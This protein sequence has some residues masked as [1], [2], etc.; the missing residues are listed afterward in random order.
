MVDMT[1]GKVSISVA[2]PHSWART[3]ELVHEH[4]AEVQMGVV[5]EIPVSQLVF[6][7]IGKPLPPYTIVGICAPPLAF[8]ALS[9]EPEIGA[10]LPCNVCV[11][12]DA[13]GGVHVTAMD[14]QSVLPLVDHPDVEPLAN[15]VRERLSRLL[16]LVVAA[17]VAA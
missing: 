10:L 7:K 13:D 11:H 14:P 5:S 16:Q 4:V 9:A 12:E 6:E 3:V 17:P 8:Q 1:Q 2:S 15:E